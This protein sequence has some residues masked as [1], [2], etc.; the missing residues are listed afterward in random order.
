M[1][2]RD[3]LAYDAFDISESVAQE[4]EVEVKTFDEIIQE[5]DYISLH[6]PLVESTKHMI[7]TKEFHQMKEDACILNA[8]R[9][10]VCLLYTSRCV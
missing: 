10:G 8:A 6:V 5:S 1:C 3:R 4:Y 7:S 9:G 2:I